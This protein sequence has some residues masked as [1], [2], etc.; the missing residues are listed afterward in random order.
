MRVLF[1]FLYID[2]QRNSV[3][4]KQTIRS[5]QK[6][7]I[8]SWAEQDRPREKL[9]ERG[10]GALTDAELIAILL[11][12]GNRNMS[13]VDLA[14]LMLNKYN[15]ELSRFARADVGELSRFQGVGKAKAVSIVAAMELGR[16][17]KELRQKAYKISGSRDCMEL[18]EPIISELAHEEFWVIY[19]NQA[20]QVIEKKRLSTGGTIGTVVDI[21][22]IMKH[23]IDILAQG[24]VLSHNHPSGNITPSKNDIKI[25][26]KLRDAA[27]MFEIRL[28]DHVIISNNEFYSFVDNGLL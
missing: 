16:R 6:K 11:S 4:L 10:P 23:A 13:A 28:L 20:N 5:M 7:S 9:L 2:C 22:L 15:N 3:S 21:K 26:Y 18:M 25:T 1:L 8:K 14:K 17:R 24:I 27:K 12:S 19:L